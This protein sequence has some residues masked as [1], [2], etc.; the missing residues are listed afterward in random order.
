METQALNLI[1]GFAE[2]GLAGIVIFCLLGMM[3]MF[4]KWFAKHMETMAQLHRDERAEWR[5]TVREVTKMQDNRQQET[6]VILQDLTRVID[7]RLFQGEMPRLR[8][9]KK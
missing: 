4:G 1:Q 2:Y 7:G 5:E 8:G 6:N 9:V 3:Y